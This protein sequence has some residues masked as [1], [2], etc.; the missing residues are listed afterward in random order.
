MKHNRKFNDRQ[1]LNNCVI[2]ALVGCVN[3]KLG[4]Q[5]VESLSRLLSEGQEQ[6][7]RLGASFAQGGTA[8]RRQ[9]GEEAVSV[10]FESLMIRSRIGGFDPENGSSPMAYFCRSLR[11]CVYYN[12]RQD[13]NDRREPVTEDEPASVEIDPLDFLV[14]AKTSDKDA[15]L[16]MARRIRS[17]LPP[18]QAEIIG[19][20][21]PF[22]DD[23]ENGVP[24]KLDPDPPV[25]PGYAK[26]RAMKAFLREIQTVLGVPHI[27][28]S[29]AKRAAK[30]RLRLVKRRRKPKANATIAVPASI[31]SD[32]KGEIDVRR[33]NAARPA[34]GHSHLGTATHVL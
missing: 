9:R 29:Q 31:L 34:E 25:L 18:E 26:S 23:D 7:S 14:E 13:R 20:I 19:I 10:L 21:Y 17:S 32:L 28:P 2:A 16:R 6:L 12:A 30:K 3:G 15:I 4:D 22:L 33:T 11:N 24:A 27:M 8:H 1:V 5:I